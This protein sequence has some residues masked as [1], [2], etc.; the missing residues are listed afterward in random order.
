MRKFLTYGAALLLACALSGCH[1][2]DPLQVQSS[3]GTRYYTPPDRSPPLRA[4]PK[5]LE[6]P[7]VTR[8]QCILT[9]TSYLQH[10]WTPT[11]RNVLHGKDSAGIQVDTPDINFRPAKTFPGWW[12]PDLVN[13]GVPYQWGGFRTLQEFDDGIAAG[14]AAGDICTGEKRSK[15]DDAVSQQAVGI[16]CSGFVSRCWQLPR[17]FST[18][19]LPLLC[20]PLASYDDLQPG[21]I[22]N[23]HNAHVVLFDSWYDAART[24]FICYETGSPPTW[25][26]QRHGLK[27][28]QI[29]ELGYRAFRYRNI[30]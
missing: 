4:L 10:Q 28:S 13:R 14:L 18:R 7:I 29:K 5:N 1:T 12:A 9:A 20:D 24:Y 3:G 23:T 15:L 19:E 22:L 8:R 30:R 27:T 11:T 26:V 2:P 16:D 25:K 17:A 21:D 6:C